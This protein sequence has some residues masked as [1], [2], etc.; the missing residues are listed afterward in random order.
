MGFSAQCLLESVTD[1]VKSIPGHS[2]DQKHMNMPHNPR[3][4]PI[5]KDQSREHGVSSL[6]ISFLFFS[7]DSNIAMYFSGNITFEASLQ[8]RRLHCMSKLTP[9]VV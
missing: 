6:L 7:E 8:D 2:T 3:S 1:T 5:T 9:S 4:I